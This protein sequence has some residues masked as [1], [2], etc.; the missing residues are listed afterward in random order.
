MPL[1]VHSDLAPKPR[2]EPRAI[3]TAPLRRSHKEHTDT[4]ATKNRN[5]LLKTAGF[6]SKRAE[7]GVD[8][9]ARDSR[10]A[11][12][13]LERDEYR[14][15][16]RK[17]KI[18]SA[19]LG[20]Q[21]LLLQS[22]RLTAHDDEVAAQVRDL[23]RQR[24]EAAASLRTVQDEKTTLVKKTEALEAEVTKLKC[25]LKSQRSQ[26]ESKM[27]IRNDA[28]LEKQ[29][30]KEMETRLKMVEKMKPTSKVMD[31]PKRTIDEI[32]ADIN[33]KK[34]EGGDATRQIESV[35]SDAGQSE[36][37]TLSLR[38]SKEKLN[39][40]LEVTQ[41]QLAKSRSAEGKALKEARVTKSENSELRAR[42]DALSQSLTDIRKALKGVES[43]REALRDSIARLQRERDEQDR[44]MREKADDLQNFKA[45]SHDEMD[46][47]E[48][49]LEKSREVEKTLAKKRD[50]QEKEKQDMAAK[51]MDL[52]ASVRRTELALEEEGKEKSTLAKTIEGLQAYINRM[53]LTLQEE[54]EEKKRLA[55]KSSEQKGKMR[56]MSATIEDLRACV[57][58]LKLASREGEE[59]NK[60]LAKEM[61]EV[62]SV[63][64][65]GR[66]ASP[67]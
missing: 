27:S 50:E 40:Q 48:L 10:I 1:R 26:D 37:K 11:E 36:E 2:S 63:W 33:S 64:V 49:K 56:D 30:R 35:R 45:K 17:E 65:T 58:R 54:E 42:G 51:I 4:L 19:D 6:Q 29:L 44:K 22:S 3:D 46:K 34:T 55:K 31:A 52:Q 24:H 38:S 14:A 32:E 67:S 7:K 61:K 66:V 20:Q 21:I 59:E 8:E 53:E 60:R 41:E 15:G 9:R 16:L 43:E 12:L 5:N 39:E 28:A 18:R 25:D 62:F 47:I 57:D 13:E 23:Q